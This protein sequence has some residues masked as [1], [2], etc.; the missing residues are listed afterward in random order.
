MFPRFR[1]QL[2]TAVDLIVEFST[3]GEYRLGAD[4]APGAPTAP[5]D[6]PGHVPQLGGAGYPA[7]R[8]AGR[9]TVAGGATG[10][11]PVATPAARRLMPAPEGPAPSGHPVAAGSSSAA[12]SG[13]RPGANS[14]ESFSHR[15][16]ASSPESFSHRPL[17]SSRA[18]SGQ[19]PAPSSSASL[20]PLAVVTRGGD[21]P[22]AADR[23]RGDRRR[24]VGE[25]HIG[26]TPASPACAPRGDRRAD[27]DRSEEQLCFAV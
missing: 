18:S 23:C 6:A 20:R 21:S 14:P 25:S 12:A 17:P 19:P 10:R 4:L 15:P 24:R 22:P 3:L 5:A 8:A 7:G 13:H 1:E 26:S 16:G 27:A 9:H 11:T 2:G